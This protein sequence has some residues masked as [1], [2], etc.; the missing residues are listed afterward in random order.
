MIPAAVDPSE[1]RAEA[2]DILGGRRFE[3]DPAPRPFRGPL[4]WLGDRINSVADV[5]GNVLSKL[6][7]WMW[8]LIALGVI[9]LLV[10][11]VT[12]GAE[13]RRVLRVAAGT[14][15]V[16]AAAPDDPTALEREADEAERNGDFER[17]VRL[18]FRAGLMRLGANGRIE[19][20]SSIT[21]GAVRQTLQSRTFDELA[22]TFD[23]ITYG[24]RDAV[25]PDAADARARWPELTRSRRS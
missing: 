3:S 7:W 8:L 9:A 6:P 16:A 21:N 14:A 2:H 19:Y 17:A 20:T 24:D 1:A 15:S 4:Q 10:W 18:R 22:L 12:R 5:I 25:P 23:E 11:F 13:R